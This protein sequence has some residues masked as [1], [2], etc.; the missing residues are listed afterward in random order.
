MSG[1]S[2]LKYIPP[3]FK[4]SRFMS[5]FFQL[6]IDA[7]KGDEDRD[8]TSISINRAIF[9]LSVPMVIEMFFEATF[10]LADAFFVARYVGTLGVAA[11]GLTVVG[12]YYYLLFS[13]GFNRCS[14]CHYSR[15]IGEK[16]TRR[17]E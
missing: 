13:L 10:A 5:N 16:E 1:V 11:V 3:H 6:F 15:R 7:F 2:F 17:L 12:N 14:Y 4:N 9:L 8:Y